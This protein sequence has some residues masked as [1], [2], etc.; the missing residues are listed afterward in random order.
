[1]KNLKFSKKKSSLFTYKYVKYNRK[2]CENKY[3]EIY[4]FLKNENYIPPRLEYKDKE[5]HKKILKKRG[6][7]KKQAKKNF[8]IKDNLLYFK[9]KDPINKNNILNLRIPLKTKVKLL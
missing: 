2:E 4:L 3:N 6:I 1:M 8:F 9:Y 5:S 7:F